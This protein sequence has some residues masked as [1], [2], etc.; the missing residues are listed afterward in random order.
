MCL[1]W[2]EPISEKTAR[3][4]RKS[5]DVAQTLP[6]ADVIYFCSPNNPTGAVASR[7]QLEALVAHANE[8]VGGATRPVTGNKEEEDRTRLTRRDLK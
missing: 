6:H 2:T 7:E 1:G 8:K 4:T 3:I 5:R